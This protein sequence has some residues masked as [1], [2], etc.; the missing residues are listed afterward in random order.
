MPN[1]IMEDILTE[2]ALDA[3][4][5]DD[6]NEV[7]SQIK[8]EMIH[9]IHSKSTT[10]VDT[11]SNTVD[12]NTVDYGMIL[13]VIIFTSLRQTDNANAYILYCLIIQIFLTLFFI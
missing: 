5:A 13:S 7:Y 11:S 12:T 8:E 6:W 3:E 10:S 2:R 9:Q 1:S 4:T